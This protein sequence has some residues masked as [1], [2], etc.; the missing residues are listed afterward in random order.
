M[1]SF[2]WGPTPSNGAAP[3]QGDMRLLFEGRPRIETYQYPVGLSFLRMEAVYDPHNL[4]SAATF[5]FDLAAATTWAE[6]EFGPGAYT[7]YADVQLPVGN[8]VAFRFGQF[9]AW[10]REA[11]H[12]NAVVRPPLTSGTMSSSFARII[13]AGTAQDSG[14]LPDGIRVNNT[15]GQPVSAVSASD[16]VLYRARWHAPSFRVFAMKQ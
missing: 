14:L 7:L 1:S 13:N 4:L 9:E 2:E 12:H 8:E 16:A 15:T 6:V 3:K 5:L 10:N 11:S